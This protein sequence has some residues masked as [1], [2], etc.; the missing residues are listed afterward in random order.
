M[1][2]SSTDLEFLQ[3]VDFMGLQR[4]LKVLGIFSRLHL[5]DGKSSY[6]KHLPLVIDYVVETIFRYKGSEPLILEFNN[7]FEGAVLPDIST[8][9]WMQSN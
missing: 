6:L 4:H 1:P 9:P 8:Q 3:W 5:R 2:E 7:W